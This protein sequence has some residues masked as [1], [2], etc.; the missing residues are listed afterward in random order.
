[1]FMR[2]HLEKSLQLYSNKVFIQ[3]DCTELLPEYLRFLRGVVDTEDLPLN[4]SR[5]VTQSSPAMVKIKDI[6]T[7]RV[8]AWLKTM[9]NKE[10]AKYDKFYHNFGPL[11]KTGVNS[12]FGNKDKLVDLLRFETTKTEKEAYTSLKEYVTRMPESQ[13]EIYY[14]SG[15]HREAVE[16]NPNLEYFRK[17]DI[18]VLLLT[19]PFDVFVVPTLGE[20]DK[21][22]VT[23][24]DKADLDLKQENQDDKEALS[25]NL[26]K[27]L[28]DIFKKTLGD[29]V[30]DV[31]ES[32]RLV[33]SAATLVVGKEGVDKQMEKMMKMM[34]QDYAGSKKILEINLS[35]PLIK[36][37]GKR[38]IGDENDPLLRNSILQI[39]DGACLIEGDLTSQT[40]FVQRMTELMVEATK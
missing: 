18:E 31:I 14:L 7:K 5:E 40:E 20:Y 32:K 38:I 36:N 16:R 17:N 21:K 33:D 4:V 23:S 6:L 26:S 11:F 13:A 15:E 27:S 24:I 12:D 25:E 35:H 9:A 30:E 37:L 3:D 22:K 28:I 29:K 2:E 10:Q 8:L 19:D 39:Y 1:M 34:N